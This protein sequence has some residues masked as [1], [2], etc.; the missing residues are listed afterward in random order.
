MG[1]L[2]THVLDTAAGKP[3][4]GVFIELHRIVG[5]GS[6]LLKSATTNIDGRTDEL[7]LNADEIEVGEYQLIFF[8]SDY[9]ISKGSE[10]SDPPFLNRVPINFGISDTTQGYHV[11]LLI[12][13]WSYSTYRGS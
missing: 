8:V 7:L 12:S 13:P 10:L 2:S 6:T 11:P 9:F 4:S 5:G 1:K 3:A